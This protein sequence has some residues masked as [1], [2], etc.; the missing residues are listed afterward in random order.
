MGYARRECGSV[1]LGMVFLVG[2]QA[3]DLFIPYMI[4]KVIDFL[5]DRDQDSINT[6]C[7]Y[8]LI[9][10][11]VSISPYLWLRLII[12]FCFSYPESVLV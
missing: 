11:V 3:S 8:M 9:I 12:L 7:I 5:E 2:G 6:Y 10:I 4:G 1:T